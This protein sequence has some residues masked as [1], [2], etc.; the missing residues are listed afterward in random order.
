MKV[1]ESEI[2]N[3]TKTQKQSVHDWVIKFKNKPFNFPK[4]DEE[5]WNEMLDDD[6]DEDVGENGKKINLLWSIKNI[7]FGRAKNQKHKRATNE[8]LY[9]SSNSNETQQQQLQ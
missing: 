4:Y 5:Y 7:T 1:K 8:L 6:D 2:K 3:S 9:S